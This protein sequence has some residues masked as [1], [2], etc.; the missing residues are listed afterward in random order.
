MASYTEINIQDVERIL[1]LYNLCN[2]SHV[3]PRNLGISNSNYQVIY[4][5]GKSV[6]LKVSNDK[7]VAQLKEEMEILTTLKNLNY[8]Y[9]LTPFPL[10]KGGYVYEVEN[11]FGVVFPFINGHPP[12][13]DNMSC[14]AIGKALAQLHLASEHKT[15]PHHLRSYHDVGCDSVGILEY[16]KT[17]PLC[18]SHFK[19]AFFEVFPQG[20]EP[21]EK[22]TFPQGIIHGDLYYD[23]TLFDEAHL[24]VVAVLDFE[25]AGVGEFIF[26]IGVSISGSCLKNGLVDVNLTKEFL[27]GYNS[28]RKLSLEETSFLNE[29]ILIGLF[30]IALWR[31]KRFK[32]G[33]LDPTRSESYLELV[34]RALSFKKQQFSL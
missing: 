1:S 10:L 8:P 13:I 17:H 14:F 32:E 9:S 7:N 33:N 19:Q 12:R 18:P 27:K 28:L 31:I 5:D 20:R 4:G 25:Q 26:D 3:I 29:A 21:F 30:S 11:Y 16:I 34:N 23:N 6:L 2:V 15:L 24:Q 22:I